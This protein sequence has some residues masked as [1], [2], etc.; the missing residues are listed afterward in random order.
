VNDLNHLIVI[1]IFIHG[2][3]CIVNITG[4][5]KAIAISVKSLKGFSDVAFAEVCHLSSR[6]I[7]KKKRDVF[8]EIVVTPQCYTSSCF[9]AFSCTDNAAARRQAEEVSD[10][11]RCSAGRLAPSTNFPSPP[12]ILKA[13]RRLADPFFSGSLG[14]QSFQFRSLSL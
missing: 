14:R 10:V 6:V 12:I 2:K 4:S 5:D 1:E 7:K 3:I 9:F 11:G 8:S 13:G